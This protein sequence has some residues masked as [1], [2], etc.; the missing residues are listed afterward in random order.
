MITLNPK[1]SPQDPVL[2]AEGNRAGSR[3][4]VYEPFSDLIKN[5]VG[6]SPLISP[7]W[8]TK[9]CCQYSESL[10]P[11]GLINFGIAE[12]VGI[13][14]LVTALFQSDERGDGRVLCMKN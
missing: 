14:T 2:S 9:S 4:H 3:Y 7:E 12:N 1:M 6:I 13:L 11:N 8:E 5:M 10:R